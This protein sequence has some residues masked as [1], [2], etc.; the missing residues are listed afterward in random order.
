[1]YQHQPHRLVIT[2]HLDLTVRFHDISAQ[3]LDG[4]KPTP[5]KSNFPNALPALTIDLKPL[6]MDYLVSKRT[7]PTIL[8]HTRIDYVSLAQESR[9][10]VVVLQTGEIVAYR[11]SKSQTTGSSR[12]P[13]NE[14]L[15]LLEH[16]PSQPGG[17]FS[18]YFMLAPLAGA[19]NVDACAISDLG[20]VYHSSPEL[21]MM[22]V[23]NGHR[24][25][26]CGIF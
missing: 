21:I 8:D 2:Y 10:A 6:F 24:F 12:E 15:I 19:G 14:M 25:P 5:I 17:R 18:P 26:G 22:Y 4:F 20:K 16:V 7:S 11:L 9:E 1:M 23:I 13:S 3:L